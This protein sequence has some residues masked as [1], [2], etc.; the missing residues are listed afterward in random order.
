MRKPVFGVFDQV[1]H[2]YREADL[3]LCFHICK[4]LVF[5]RHGSYQKTCKQISCTVTSGFVLVQ[6][7]IYFLNPKVNQVYSVSASYARSRSPLASALSVEET[8]RSARPVSLWLNFRSL[9]QSATKL[10]ICCPIGQ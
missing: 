7:S 6:L 8:A 2:G 9:Q 4:K 1:P 5:S 3:H 10:S